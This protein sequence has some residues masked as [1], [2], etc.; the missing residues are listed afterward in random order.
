MLEFHR[1]VYSMLC[2]YLQYHSGAWTC[3]LDAPRSHLHHDYFTCAVMNIFVHT[4][5]LIKYKKKK[6]KKNCHYF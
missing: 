4:C 1:C 2:E 5:C 6:K 3:V